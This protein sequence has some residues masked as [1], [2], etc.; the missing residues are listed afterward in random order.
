MPYLTA[1]DMASRTMRKG[2]VDRTDAEDDSA[3]AQDAR[4]RAAAVTG[5]GAK[6]MRVYN[7][8]MPAKADEPSEAQGARDTAA[9]ATGRKR[10]S[11]LYDT[12]SED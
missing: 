6:N 4:E 12:D 7:K 5:R 2:W 3:A 11:P 1:Q 9:K 10:R 8:T